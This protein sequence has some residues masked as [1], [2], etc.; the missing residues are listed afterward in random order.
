MFSKG[1][2]VRYEDRVYVVREPA[3]ADGLVSIWPAQVPYWQRRSA[4]KTVPAE[5]LKPHG[6]KVA[7]AAKLPGATTC[8]ICGLPVAVSKLGKIARHGYQ[9]AAHGWRTPGC[10]GATHTPFEHDCER[11]R[12][13]VNFLKEHRERM[14]AHCLGLGVPGVQVPGPQEPFIGQDGKQL[15]M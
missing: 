3:N 7:K 11:L 6:A 9:R 10:F 2:K 5:K 13:Y 15:S 4:L 1:D 14:H 12:W 8:Q